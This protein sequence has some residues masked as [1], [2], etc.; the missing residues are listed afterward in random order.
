MKDVIHMWGRG[1]IGNLYNLRHFA[2]S[3][4]LL[5]K[6][7]ILKKAWAGGGRWDGAPNQLLGVFA[8]S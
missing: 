2:V 3:L 4:K 7:I 8:F 1:Y 5:F 6:N